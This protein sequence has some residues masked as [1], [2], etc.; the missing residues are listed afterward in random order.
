MVH[1]FASPIRHSPSCLG[2]R[3]NILHIQGLV[4]TLDRFEKCQTSH[5]LQVTASSAS[6]CASTCVCVCKKSMALVYQAAQPSHTCQHHGV[7]RTHQ[8]CIGTCRRF[9]LDPNSP[10]GDRKSVV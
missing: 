7:S 9:L 2:V 10:A 6:A 4:A 5:R 1:Q 3:Y 8:I